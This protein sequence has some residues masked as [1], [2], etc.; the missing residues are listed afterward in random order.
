[1]LAG[2]LVVLVRH[3]FLQQELMELT[4]RRDQE[5]LGA[6]ADVEFRDLGAFRFQLFDQDFGVAV[7][8]FHGLQVTEALA[9]IVIVG[10]AVIGAGLHVRD[11]VHDQSG[12]HRADLAEAVRMGQTG[13]DGAEATHGQAGD[14]GV[15]RTHRQ[16]EGLTDVV[17]QLDGH[18]GLEG[19][20]GGEAV[21]IEGVL[22]VR[23]DDGEVVLGLQFCRDPVLGLAG[24]AVQDK[25]GLHRTVEVGVVLL[26]NVGTDVV[27]DPH[28]K[29]CHAAQGVGEIVDFE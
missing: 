21:K 13:V 6:A 15:F 24:I 16:T 20:A 2:A 25:E 29:G 19:V 1:M 9:V 18:Q 27:G 23:A 11:T 17:H 4:V 3:A 22:G 14:V 8:L 26:R 5:V 12:A 7:A 10:H 28:F